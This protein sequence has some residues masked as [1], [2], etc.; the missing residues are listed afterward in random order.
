MP[1]EYGDVY[2]TWSFDRLNGQGYIAE[3]AYGLG[4]KREY[5]GCAAIY[6]YENTTESSRLSLNAFDEAVTDSFAFAFSMYYDMTEDASV[7][8][9]ARYSDGGE[10]RIADLKCADSGKWNNYTM[11][12]DADRGTCRIYLNGSAVSE[13][14][15]DGGII[16]DFAFEF[17]SSGFEDMY[18]V[19]NVS[20]I[21]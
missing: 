15:F 16:T 12:F 21:Y 8:L 18:A 6:G 13:A 5:D 1:G 10:A 9:L 3:T 2:G 14:A 4:G 17:M 11:D 7:Y 19:D 20:L